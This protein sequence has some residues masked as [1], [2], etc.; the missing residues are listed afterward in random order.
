MPCN[1]LQSGP[2]TQQSLCVM[3]VVCCPDASRVNQCNCHCTYVSYCK[4]HSSLYSHQHTPACFVRACC[5][6]DA[7][8]AATPHTLC[9]VIQSYA[10]SH[11]GA[12][13]C[14]SP[15]NDLI[16]VVIGSLPFLAGLPIPSN[17]CAR[18]AKPADPDR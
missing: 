12:V 18:R 16:Q 8:A 13:M 7:F 17:M 14:H 10:L 4:G 1:M 5:G 11:A 3:A 9:H 6:A 15:R 2:T